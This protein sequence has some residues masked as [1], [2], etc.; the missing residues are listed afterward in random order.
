MAE[1]LIFISGASS[2]IGD[3]LARSVPWTPARVVGISRSR[4]TAADEHVAADLT[5]PSAWDIVGAAFDREV[6]DFAGD[7]IVFVHAA[8]TIEPMGFAGE[9]DTEAYTANVL[10]NSA[11]PQ[12]L[13]HRFLA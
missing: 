4:A 10:L 13:G 11:A 3:A 9:V 12:V 2:G 7:R 5:D 6:A 1:S 8:G